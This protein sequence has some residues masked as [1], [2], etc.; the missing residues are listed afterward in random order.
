[1]NEKRESLAIVAVL[2]I[3]VMAGGYW[4]VASALG[5][6]ATLPEAAVTRVLLVTTV[7]VLPC[8]AAAAFKTGRTME[9]R[10]AEVG[11]DQRRDEGYRS[12]Y[13]VG[14]AESF[15]LIAQLRAESVERGDAFLKGAEKGLT[16][17]DK[18]VTAREAARLP[19]SQPATQVAV[20]LPQLTGGQFVLQPQS[21]GVIEM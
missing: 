4:V 19:E 2:A 8:V 14:R 15:R 21:D 11:H 9:L 20:I 1:M 13:A 10:L 6:L 17:T 12:G 5:Y 18:L 7:C 3:V 16:L